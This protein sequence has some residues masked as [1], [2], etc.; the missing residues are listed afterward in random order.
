MLATPS[1]SLELDPQWVKD[2]VSTQRCVCASLCFP[3][4]SSG[5]GWAAGMLGL[6]CDVGQWGWGCFSLDA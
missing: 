4:G 1:L 6:E 3:V 5:L 2:E